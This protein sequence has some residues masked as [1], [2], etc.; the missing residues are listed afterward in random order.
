M[1]ERWKRREVLRLVVMGGAGMAVLGCGGSEP[2][3]PVCT[4]VTALSASDADF[5]RGQGYV[6]R[7]TRPG[8]T[9][10]TCNFYA[11][12]SAPTQCGTCTLIRGPISPQGYCNLWVQI[13]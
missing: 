3:G 11:A 9:C 1:S 10:D 7:S 4:D 12:G 2:S 8:R 5:R 6:D 13:S